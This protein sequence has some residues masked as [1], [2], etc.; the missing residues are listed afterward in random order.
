[1]TGSI[2]AMWW[3]S[4]RRVFAA[5]VVSTFGSLMS[6]LAAL[7]ADASSCLVPAWLLWRVSEPPETARG[8]GHAAWRDTWRALALDVREGTRAVAAEPTLRT[9][10]YVHTVWALGSVCVPLSGSAQWGG[11]LALAAQQLVADAGAVAAQI[12]DR[13][14][15]QSHA[16][17]AALLAAWRC[18]AVART[19]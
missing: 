4:F 18:R 12:S 5:D 15:R 19:C 13:T 10:A 7:V 17:A 9:I 6:R 3:T 8:P 16:D 14:L 11:M 2:R 1:M